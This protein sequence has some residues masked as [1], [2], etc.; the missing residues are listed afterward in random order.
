LSISSEEIRVEA[1][2]QHRDRQ[3]HHTTQHNTTQHNNEKVEK[4]II[5]HNKKDKI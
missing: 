2:G 4:I 1:R 3:L 5:Q